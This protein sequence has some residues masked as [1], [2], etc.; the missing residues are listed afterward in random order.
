VALGYEAYR[1]MAEKEL[2]ALAE[3]TRTR[4][5]LLD[6]VC[7]HRLGDV[8]IGEPSLRVVIRS[9]HRQEGITALDWF[10]VELKAR[11]PI[12]KWGVTLEGERFPSTTGG[13]DTETK[14]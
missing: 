6:L 9:R 5:G 3:E 8:P 4:F 7:W 2:Q 12:W 14:G 13:S 11:V 1:G 10:V